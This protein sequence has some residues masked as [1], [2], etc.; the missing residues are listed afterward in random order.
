MDIAPAARDDIR[1]FDPPPD[2][3][4]RERWFRSQDDLPLFF[5]DYGDPASPRMPVLCLTGLTRNAKDFHKLALRLCGQRRVLAPDY[6][7]RGRSARDPDWRNYRPETYVADALD[8]LTV[9]GVHRVVV[10]GTSMG[11]LLAMGMAALRPTALAGAILNDIGPELGSDG[12]GRIRDYIAADR[13][14]SDWESAVGELKR[15][16]PSLS[17]DSPETWLRMADASYRRGD[18]GLLHFDWDV[19]LTRGMQANAAGL[20]DLWPLYRALGRRPLLAIRGELSDVLS[21]PTF[22]RM[23]EEKPDIMRTIV[24]NVGHVPALDE[25]QATVAIDE[26]INQF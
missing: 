6:R 2:S 25:P 19:A 5:R 14:V 3:G 4:F 21:Q 13:P 12:Y 7:G 18:D 20:P 17:L 24:P 10:I 15:L 23:A 9:A 11:G 8:L 1:P 22:D 16:F 26:F